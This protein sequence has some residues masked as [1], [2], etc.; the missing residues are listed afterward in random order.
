MKEIH[1]S[2]N[3]LVA[4]LTQININHTSFYFFC[5]LAMLGQFVLKGILKN[6]NF[7]VR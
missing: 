3:N 6:V 4:M 2:N 7:L 1:R 5:I